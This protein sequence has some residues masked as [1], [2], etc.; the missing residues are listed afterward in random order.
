MSCVPECRVLKKKKK[1]EEAI[2]GNGI[3]KNGEKKLN[4]IMAM[5][6]PKMG[7]KKKCCCR[8]LGRNFKKSVM[9]TIFL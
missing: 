3:A 9:F 2:C 6:L 1:K 4:G 7:G 5:S 8:N